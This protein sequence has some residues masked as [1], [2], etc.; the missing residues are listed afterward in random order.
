MILLG[1]GT[2]RD[3]NRFWRIQNI[4]ESQN[5]RDLSKG[6]SGGFINTNYEKGSLEETKAPGKVTPKI[7]IKLLGAI[8]Q[9]LQ[10]K[11]R[12]HR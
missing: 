9:E 2:K 7:Q 11:E 12:S 1:L 6:N 3:N 8:D 4:K 5:C 10:P